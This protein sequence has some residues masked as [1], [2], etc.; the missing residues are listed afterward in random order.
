MGAFGT[1]LSQFHFSQFGA[2]ET[3]M[4]DMFRYYY[5]TTYPPHCSTTDTAQTDGRGSRSCTE[6]HENH[7]PLC[8]ARV[9][10]VSVFFMSVFTAANAHTQTLRLMYAADAGKITP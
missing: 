9:E 3:F 2:A 4:G 10:A 7:P 8:A 1:Q 6:T 5:Q